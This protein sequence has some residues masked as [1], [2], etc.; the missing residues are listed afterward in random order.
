[1]S[2]EWAI[3][4]TVR[5]TKRL[6]A[7]MTAGVSHFVVEWDPAAPRKLNST[8]MRRYRA[9]RDQLLAEVAARMELQIAVIEI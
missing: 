6:S 9:G 7:H 5:I 3:S 2:G 4:K 8:G 1:M